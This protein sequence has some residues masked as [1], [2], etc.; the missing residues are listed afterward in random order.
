MVKYQAT[1]VSVFLV[2]DTHK[3]AYYQA[4][5]GLNTVSFIHPLNL[6]WASGYST[7]LIQDTAMLERFYEYPIDI[8]INDY[9]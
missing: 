2:E 1:K 3:L 6:L 5:N 4:L 8:I 9:F 7:Q